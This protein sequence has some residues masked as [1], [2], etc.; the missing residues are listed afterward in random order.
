VLTTDWLYNRGMTT[1]LQHLRNR[2][3]NVELHRPMLDDEN[4]VATF[5]LW[6]VSGQLVG[7]Q[8][9]RRNGE[10][11]PQNDPKQGKYYTYKSPGTVALWGLE[12]LHLTPGL[13]FVTEGVFDAARLVSHGFSAVAVLSNNPTTDVRNWV[14]SL[15]RTVVA[16]CD[17]DKAGRLLAK[18]GHTAV[19]TVDKDVG[20]ADEQWVVSM[21]AQFK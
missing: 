12:S 1:L 6:N 7:F 14:M 19:F 10:K 18:V 17:N 15:G 5:F 8:H 4:D 2:H 20:D 9:Y 13:L 11:R 21:L 3:M 16:V